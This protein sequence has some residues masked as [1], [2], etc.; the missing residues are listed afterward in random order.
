MKVLYLASVVDMPKSE[1][2]GLGGTSHVIE[3][4]RHLGGLGLDVI[5]F[6]R[7]GGFGEEWIEHE[8]VRIRRL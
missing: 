8:G 1:H 6:C 4:A 3:V 5:V 7:G 2:G